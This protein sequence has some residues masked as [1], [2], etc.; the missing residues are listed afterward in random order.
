MLRYTRRHDAK[1]IWEAIF[2]ELRLLVG[3]GHSDEGRPADLRPDAAAFLKYYDG[4]SWRQV[5]ENLCPKK[6][7]DTGHTCT[8]HCKE[9][10]RKAVA[11]YFKRLK[12]DALHL[13]PVTG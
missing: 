2:R 9:N 7:I 6:Y 1:R 13:P 8:K 4:L 10:F 12:Q 3:I 11:N 5:A